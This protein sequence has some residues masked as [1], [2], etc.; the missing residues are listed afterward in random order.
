M[1]RNYILIGACAFLAL[2]VSCNVSP[3]G[4]QN[5][6]SKEDCTQVD[7]QVMSDEEKQTLLEEKYK[8]CPL[9]GDKFELSVIKGN[10]PTLIP[11]LSDNLIFGYFDEIGSDGSIISKFLL[12]Y[13]IAT[14][15]IS[16]LVPPDSSDYGETDLFRSR[17]QGYTVHDNHLYLIHDDLGHL[18]LPYAPCTI[19]RI[20]ID[21]FSWHT[22][23]E[24]EI[25]GEN[26]TF[27]DD[28]IK[29]Q[30]YYITKVCE[31]DHFENEYGDSIKW[32]QL[33]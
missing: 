6:Q 24:P 5:R 28:K 17:Y 18:Y 26:T 27:I 12:V 29:A 7:N 8:E 3:K 20:D 33:E 22:I 25:Y 16:F 30:I 14:D 4:V 21:D 23:G 31:E 2:F 10:T 19:Y 1:K 13:D 32:I 15:S 9:V 11:T